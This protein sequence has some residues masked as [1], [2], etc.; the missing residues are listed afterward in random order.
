MQI[1]YFALLAH[2]LNQPYLSPD[3]KHIERGYTLIQPR[4]GTDFIL[5]KASWFCK[6]F[7]EP[8]AVDPY[9]QAI[10]NVYQDLTGEGSYH[11]K[12]IYDLETFYTIL[13]GH[14]PEEHLLSH[15]LLE[16]AFVK[17]G[18][19]SNICLYDVFTGFTIF[20]PFLFPYVTIER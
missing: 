16:G 19:A 6:I 20:N 18:F 11:G 13:S 5:S 7:S 12:G 15:D 8:T 4:V 2:P 10:S 9:T 1:Y 17:V 3:K 14:F